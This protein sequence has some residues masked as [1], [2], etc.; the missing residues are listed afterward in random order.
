MGAAPAPDDEA[1]VVA[2]VLLAAGRSA[3]WGGGQKVLAPL[4]GMPLVAR[5]ARTALNGGARPVIVVLGNAADDVRA[6]LEGL[7][8]ACVENR[9]YARGIAGSIRC[10]LSVLPFDAAGA[11]ILLADMPFVSAQHLRALRA[12]FADAQCAKIC[13]PSY[14]G[15]R[16]NPVLWPRAHFAALKSVRGDVGGRPL[17]QR[18]HEQVMLVEMA[19]DGVLLDIDSQ[20]HLNALTEQGPPAGPDERE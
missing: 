1:P 19:D 18:L 9:D 6:A 12:A 7:D 3:R 15:R 17:L 4:G 10:G 2:T 5:A 16:G 11:L 8:V 13:V 14:R 20:E